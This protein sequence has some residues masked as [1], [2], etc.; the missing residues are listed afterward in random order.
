MASIEESV[1]AMIPQMAAEIGAKIKEQTLRNIEYTTAKAIAEEVQA[2]VAE[3]VMPLVKSELA[4]Q[5][6]E[7]KAAILVGARGVASALATSMIESF[8]KK[9]AGYEGDKLITAVFGPFFRGY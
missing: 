5:T 9:L 3:H 7:I 2:Y 6:D 1:T 8:T 4:A